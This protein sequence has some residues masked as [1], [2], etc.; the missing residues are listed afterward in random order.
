MVLRVAPS[1]ARHTASTATERE[2][3]QPEVKLRY[4][5]GRANIRISM[6]YANLVWR[7]FEIV[8]MVPI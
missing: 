7:L 8:E 6:G 4:P 2:D 3:E 5:E 1:L